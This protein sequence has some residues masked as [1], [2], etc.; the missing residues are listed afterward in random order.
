M[1]PRRLSLPLLATALAAVLALSGASQGAWASPAPEDATGSIGTDADQLGGILDI[2]AVSSSE[3]E[4]SDAYLSGDCVTEQGLTLCQSVDFD[5]SWLGE[6]VWTAYA[7]VGHADDVYVEADVTTLEGNVLDSTGHAAGLGP[8][9]KIQWVR[10]T[11]PGDT[12]GIT[13]PG[14]TDLGLQ[15]VL[16][17]PQVAGVTAFC[18]A[19][20]EGDMSYPTR[21]STEPLS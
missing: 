1:T 19:G 6:A 15:M 4:N 3:Y 2:T 17:V 5:N 7:A 18:H 8:W 11:H 9:V 20:P 13:I 21:C 16:T 12:H 14:E 10:P